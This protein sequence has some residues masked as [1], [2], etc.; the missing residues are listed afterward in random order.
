MF[1]RGLLRISLKQIHSPKPI[2]DLVGTG[3]LYIQKQ[4]EEEGRERRAMTSE[5]RTT[6]LHF[7]R[8]KTMPKKSLHCSVSSPSPGTGRVEQRSRAR[9]HS[10]VS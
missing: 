7:S 8:K 4:T 3:Q 2:N 9:L 10:E 5:Y 1:F 6:H